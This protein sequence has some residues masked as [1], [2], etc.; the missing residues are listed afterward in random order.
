MIELGCCDTVRL[1]LG[2]RNTDQKLTHC[3]FKSTV[4]WMMEYENSSYPLTC[5]TISDCDL[6]IH[7]I[8]RYVLNSA[9][10]IKLN[11]S[12]DTKIIISDN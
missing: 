11:R 10:L 2:L 12:N 5:P 3:V 8:S 9:H 4:L 1:F 7:M 6:S